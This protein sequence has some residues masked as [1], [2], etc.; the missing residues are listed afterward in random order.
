MHPNYQAIYMTVQQIPQ[1]CVAS[2]GQIAT[3]AGLPGRARQ[4][5]YALHALPPGNPVPW[6]RVVN[7]RGQIS[8]PTATTAFANQ[9]DA[10]LADGVEVD[11][12]G[13]IDLKRYGWNP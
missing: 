7:S 1:G 12:R 4:V 10:L 9:R 6:F 11:G 2:Y 13:R 5:G 8:R 3:L